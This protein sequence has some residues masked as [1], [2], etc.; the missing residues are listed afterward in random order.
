MQD[1][2]QTCPTETVRVYSVLDVEKGPCLLFV[3]LRGEVLFGPERTREGAKQR[4]RLA[5]PFSPVFVDVPGIWDV[6]CAIVNAWN[7]L[8]HNEEI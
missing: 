8:P 2:R 1:N 6:E 3:S 7:N 5:N 4:W